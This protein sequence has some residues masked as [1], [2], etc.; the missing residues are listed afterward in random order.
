M[1]QIGIDTGYVKSIEK[2]RRLKAEIRRIE[3]EYEKQVGIYEN[4]DVSDKVRT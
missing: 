1:E 2:N 4:G 3:A